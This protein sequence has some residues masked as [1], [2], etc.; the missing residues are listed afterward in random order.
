MIP[1]LRIPFALAADGSAAVVEQDSL[2]EV[3]QNVRVLL[4]T[5]Q[6][7]RLIP[8]DYGIPDPTFVGLDEQDLAAAVAEWEPRAAV[9]VTVEPGTT[10]K[11]TVGV[12]LAATA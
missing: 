12:T 11:V 3:T 6:G 2:A 1:H 7:S 10:E 8:A 5:V 4:G 9:T